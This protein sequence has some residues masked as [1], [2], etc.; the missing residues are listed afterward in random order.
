M[1]GLPSWS[2]QCEKAGVAILELHNKTVMEVAL[3]NKK[4]N[5]AHL[6]TVDVFR[7]NTCV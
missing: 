3:E 1:R 5:Y 6:D 7:I 2:V 4:H